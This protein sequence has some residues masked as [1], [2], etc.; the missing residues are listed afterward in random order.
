MKVGDT[1]GRARKRMIHGD[2][3]VSKEGRIH[4]S[5]W[6]QRKPQKHTS[7]LLTPDDKF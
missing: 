1:R 4:I 2:K 5:E 7:N 3:K 6:K